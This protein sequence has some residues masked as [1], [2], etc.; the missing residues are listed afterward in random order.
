MSGGSESQGCK[1]GAHHAS[2]LVG[3]NRD[4][5]T[6]EEVIEKMDMVHEELLQLQDQSS[7]ASDLETVRAYQRQERRL[8]FNLRRLERAEMRLLQSKYTS[9]FT[10]QL[11]NL[12][13]TMLGRI[14]G[15]EKQVDVLSKKVKATEAVA[16]DAMDIASSV[17]YSQQDTVE[18][19]DE[20]RVTA[21]GTMKKLKDLRRVVDVIDNRTRTNNVVV[22]G[23]T[24]T[25]PKNEVTSLLKGRQGLRDSV[26]DA[27]YIGKHPRPDG[28]GF[29]P[30][31]PALVKFSA[32][33]DKEQFLRW[34]KDRHEITATPDMSQLRRQGIKRLRAVAE[35]LER[36][37]PTIVVRR[38][39]AQLGSERF[40]AADFADDHIVIHGSYI[41]IK[42]ALAKWN[43]EGKSTCGRAPYKS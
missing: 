24:S 12:E 1:V 16:N 6:Y 34:S 39:Y 21:D 27:Y 33:S 28:A 13:N 15:L 25:N 17:Q 29:R 5:V 35:E 22:Y 18:E 4:D 41:D 32:T 8:Q 10:A 38:T 31:G 26:Q 43:C 14:H 3:L 23:L 37:F 19:L 20:I 9:V 7:E 30:R 42:T 2:L 36:K 40:C 11:S